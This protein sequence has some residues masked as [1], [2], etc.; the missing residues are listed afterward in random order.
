MAEILCIESSGKNCSVAWSSNGCAIFTKERVDEQY[1]HAE[2][3]HGFIEC[4]LKESGRKPDA[5]AVSKGPGSYTGLRIGVSTAKGLSFS[6][7]I[8]LI[9]V[10]TIDAMALSIARRFPG[11]DKIVVMIDARRMEVYAGFFDG[12]GRSLSGIRAAVLNESFFNGFETNEKIL[13]C[14]DGA[15]K[16]FSLTAGRNVSIKSLFPSATML[17]EPAEKKYSVERFEN[18]AYFEPYYMKDFLP[19]QA[20]DTL[21]EIK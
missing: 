19:G 17:A 12:A 8:P 10:G 3:L 13:L 20:K 7:N 14:G 18:L 16:A 1:S 6:W 21:S 9:G 5:V 2:E 4:T 11:F 15:A